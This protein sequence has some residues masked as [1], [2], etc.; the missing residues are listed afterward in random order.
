MIKDENSQRKLKFS[1]KRCLRDVQLGSDVWGILERYRF[2]Q[3]NFYLFGP[4]LDMLPKSSR[5]R[6]RNVV[7]RVKAKATQSDVKFV[8][9]MSATSSRNITNEQPTHGEKFA[10]CAMLKLFS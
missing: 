2:A 10:A 5:T 6:R 7:C 8:I 3:V 4:R 1:T 9:E